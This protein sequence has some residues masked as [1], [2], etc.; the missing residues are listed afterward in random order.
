MGM[1]EKWKKTVDNKGVFGA[2][3]TDLSKAFNR[4]PHNLIVVKLE[5]YGFDINALRLIHDYLT[6][7]KERVKIN[8]TYSLWKHI[9]YGVPQGSIL[10]PLLFNIFLCDLFYFME[11]FY[12]SSY[13]GNNTIYTADKNEDSAIS[14]L[15]TSSVTLL[16]G[17]KII[18]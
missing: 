18:S 8:D 9:L 1:I 13:A 10:E 17:S 6:N 4:I 12:M 7:R 3:S 14:V 2:L 16:N 5:A 11:D 15:E